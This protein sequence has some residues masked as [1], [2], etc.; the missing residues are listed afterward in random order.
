M[1]VPVLDD[2]TTSLVCSL[3]IEGRIG[4]RSRRAR[5]SDRTCGDVSRNA[6]VAHPGQLGQD[7][8]RR[9]VDVDPPHDT[10]FVFG[11]PR[12][13]GW[14]DHGQVLEQPRIVGIRQIDEYRWRGCTFRNDVPVLSEDLAQFPDVRQRLVGGVS[15]DHTGR[16]PVDIRLHIVAQGGR[17]SLRS[18]SPE[19]PDTS[20]R[21]DIPS[22]AVGAIGGRHPTLGH[23]HHVRRQLAGDS[24]HN[25]DQRNH[26][27]GGELETTWIGPLGLS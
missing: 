7:E 3:Q 11:H 9:G 8:S 26:R 14:I 5:P 2:F 13:G 6:L 10:R 12:C 17:R 23:S 16:L 1:F 22:K 4:R 25:P 18:G 24:R 19:T 21:R 27:P 20:M 15:L